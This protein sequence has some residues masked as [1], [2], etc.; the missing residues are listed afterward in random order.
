MKKLTA[1]LMTITLT[2]GLFSNAAFGLTKDDKA[3]QDVIKKYSLKVAK[4]VPKGITPVKIDNP[5]DIAKAIEK[6]KSTDKKIDV[7]VPSYASVTPA[8]ATA[9]TNKKGKGT[10]VGNRYLTFATYL[11]ISAWYNW[12][13]RGTTNRYFRDIYKIESKLYGLNTGTAWTQKDAYSDIKDGGKKVTVEIE[14]EMVFYILSK[15]TI[16][17]WTQYQYWTID[18]KN[19]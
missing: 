13:T 14:G 4:K 18:F 12:E 1:L 7:S 8:L 10:K 15:D 9:S 17:Y 2:L 3:M 6:I 11:R 19:P 5:A 16:R